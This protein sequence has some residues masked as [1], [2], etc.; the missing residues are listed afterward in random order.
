M[1]HLGDTALFRGLIGFVRQVVVRR[2][3]MKRSRRFHRRS[4]RIRCRG[5]LERTAG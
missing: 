2:P 5:A 4:E 3:I 1:P